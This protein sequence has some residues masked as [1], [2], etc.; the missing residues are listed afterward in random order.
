MSNIACFGEPVYSC[1]L[2]QGIRDGF[3]APCKVV[4][5]H[6]DRDVKGYRS[7]RGILAEVLLGR[8]RASARFVAEAGGLSV[9]AAIA[10]RREELAELCW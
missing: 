9:Y 4:K 6:I 2:K 3:L 7:D 8:H 10:E 1:S 5:V